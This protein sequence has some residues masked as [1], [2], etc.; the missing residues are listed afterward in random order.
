LLVNKVRAPEYDFDLT[1]SSSRNLS[2]VFRRSAPASTSL[3]HEN[4]S[5]EDIPWSKQR[6]FALGAAFKS[7]AW[8]QGSPDD[9]PQVSGK[10][11]PTPGMT[12]MLINREFEVSQGFG[13]MLKAQNVQ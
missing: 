10:R 6:I 7:K 9:L 3:C 2:K 5:S 11:V 12:T 4:V 13:R 8:S 1:V